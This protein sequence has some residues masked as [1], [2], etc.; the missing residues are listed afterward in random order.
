MRSRR[1]PDGAAAALSAQAAFPAQAVFVHGRD[2]PMRERGGEA[3]RSHAASLHAASLLSAGC[4]AG[5][6]ITGWAGACRSGV[7]GA[8][9]RCPMPHGPQ[10][11]RDSAVPQ[12]AALAHRGGLFVR[13]E[14]VRGVVGVHVGVPRRASAGQRR[15]HAAARRRRRCR[16]AEPVEEVEEDGQ[17]GAAATCTSRT[18][19]VSII[20]SQSC[21][22]EPKCRH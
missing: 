2:G 18:I 10:Q 13:Q 15:P 9:S 12:R 8:S 20:Q 3:A 5:L 14:D 17:E 6:S 4:L 1:S 22:N 11:Y 16:A 21:Q 7:F 19:T